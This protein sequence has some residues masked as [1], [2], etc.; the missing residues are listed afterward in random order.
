MNKKLIHGLKIILLALIWVTTF[1]EIFVLKFNAYW[2]YSDVI[3]SYYLSFPYGIQ[4]VM[5]YALAAVIAIILSIVVTKLE[6]YI[7]DW[8]STE[9]VSSNGRLF[10]V[11]LS[12]ELGFNF[13]FLINPLDE[14]RNASINFARKIGQ[15]FIN[16]RDA[17][18]TF[19]SFL[20]WFII[21][22]CVV[23][24][25]L[26]FFD[27]TSVK[28][29][30]RE[31]KESFAFL[32]VLVAVYAA[33]M[34]L[35]AMSYF[36]TIGSESVNF[37]FTNYLF[38]SLLL[39]TFI[40]VF[41]RF[42]YSKIS[43]SKYLCGIL[44]LLG[45]SIPLSNILFYELESGRTVAGIFFILVLC[46]AGVIIIV[47]NIIKSNRIV[48]FL[49]RRELSLSC[50]HPFVFLCAAY[51]L[52]TSLFI[53]LIYIL[54]QHSIYV[55]QPKRFYEYGILFSLIGFALLSFL[56]RR[57][58]LWKK[59]NWKSYVY[60]MLVVGFVFMSQQ[61][62]LS[63]V[64]SADIFEGANYGVLI[65]DFLKF[66]DIPV[67][68]HYGHHMLTNV[69]DGIIYGW[70]NGDTVG[71]AYS[72]YDFLTPIMYVAFFYFIKAYMDYDYALLITLLFPF[73]SQWSY[74]GLGIFTVLFVLRSQQ[75]NSYGNG[76]ILWIWLSF[77]VLLRL[78]LG[79]AAIL[80]SVITLFIIIVKKHDRELLI[81]QFLGMVTV[82]GIYGCAWF[83]ICYLKGI[84]PISRLIAFLDMSASNPTWAYTTL[85]DNSRIIYAWF[86][87]M[88][89]VLIIFALLSLVTNKRIYLKIPF[90][91]KVTLLFI[92]ILYFS[93]FQRGLVRHSVA[94]N[95][96]DLM[97]F[98]VSFF[99]AMYVMFLL[100]RK[101][102]MLPV[103]AIF[104]F[105]NSLLVNGGNVGISTLVDSAVLKIEPMVEGWTLTRAQRENLAEDPSYEAMTVLGVID[106]EQYTVT[107]VHLSDSFKEQTRQIGE[108]L[109]ML[110]TD[111]ES[112]LDFVYESFLYST[113]GREDPVYIAQSPTMMSGEYSQEEYIAEIEAKQIPLIF[114]P[115]DGLA[116][117][118]FDGVTN[119]TRYYKVAEYIYQ[120][121]R[122]LCQTGIYAF[123]ARND[124][125]DEFMQ[126]LY[127]DNYHVELTSVL[128]EM[129]VGDMEYEI[130]TFASGTT[131]NLYSTGNDPRLTGVEQLIDFSNIT[132]KYLSLKIEY[133]YE[134]DDPEN[135]GSFQL[136]YKNEEDEY[137]TEEKSSRANITDDGVAYLSFSNDGHVKLRLDIPNNVNVKISEISIVCASQIDWDYENVMHAVNLV[138]LPYI[139]ASYD[140]K[141]AVDNS[142]ITDATQADDNIWEISNVEE[143]KKESGNYIKI[144]I[145]YCPK[146]DIAET[147]TETEEMKFDSDYELN[148]YI[149]NSEKQAK[150]E[151][152]TD[153]MGQEEISGKLSLWADDESKIST[154][155]F[156]IK[157]GQHSYLFRISS[158]YRWYT[159]G[160][161]K[162]TVHMNSD[163]AEGEEDP[164]KVTAVS[165]LE[166]D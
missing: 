90:V 108:L 3:D 12:L 14:K 110:L 106:R 152:A 67:V 11:I 38:I 118:G 151:L 89:P 16:N 23:L 52:A 19:T 146:D 76:V 101:Y 6:V 10:S 24:G 21:I 51:P 50:L 71:A 55:A 141:S 37:L 30:L 49:E 44:A 9:S 73:Y 148:N 25:L 162:L 69:I 149:I 29:R 56:T 28:R 135:T 93:N 32:K 134:C 70:L 157:E 112:Y 82:G 87:L 20:G 165:V 136:F 48:D 103:L 13:A 43:F 40:Y 144:D 119:F 47:S 1:K 122:P 57:L 5:D 80:A 7:S 121:Y 125:Y 158:D 79:L 161:S 78:D 120:N 156:T 64:G 95:N 128:P 124:R 34:V 129:Q 150:T 138:D 98:S 17:G 96:V 60:P 164:F 130:E 117:I 147:E 31:N 131:L 77:M 104:L 85:G 58:K 86:Y 54:N 160:I 18:R 66:G 45:L 92:A 97:T 65:T 142:V 115:S 59:I 42:K 53:E 100:K 74:A 107:R 15:G 33:W 109:D 84:N 83:I 133:T 68:D 166:G 163:N 132:N 91:G 139:W 81:N 35:Y 39:G 127:S 22:S 159:S 27:N 155:T 137:F 114:M 140:E 99:F 126:K 94:E 143:I 145:E 111:D 2:N 62:A 113:L 102:V 153:D 61:V 154:A 8:T 88:L 36:R 123:W 46:F 116:R 105:I 72:I 63:S 4:M 75:K 41:I 26:L